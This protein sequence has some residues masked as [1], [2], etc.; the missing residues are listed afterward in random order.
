MGG[1]FLPTVLGMLLGLVLVFVYSASTR[2]AIAS[3]ASFI[4][5]LLVIPQNHELRY[6][7]FIPL[8][9]L[10]IIAQNLGF[11]SSRLQIG[12][13]VY[14]VVCAILVF[15]L[16]FDRYRVSPTTPAEL[17]PGVAR[18]FWAQYANSQNPAS[19]CINVDIPWGIFWAGPSFNE[20]PV[21]YCNSK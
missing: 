9:G 11:L 16:T 2:L 6:W 10:Y 21:Q 3:L 4:I 7:L 8:C 15:N 17:T 18:E 1:W 12:L 20:Y 19:E 14:F 13:K 5:M